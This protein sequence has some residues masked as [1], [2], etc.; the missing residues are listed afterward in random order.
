MKITLTAELTGQEIVPLDCEII[1]TKEQQTVIILKE[2]T[3]VKLLI[4]DLKN[5]NSPSVT[6]SNVILYFKYDNKK[7]LTSKFASVIKN[8]EKNNTKNF[9]IAFRNENGEMLPEYLSYELE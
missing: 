6:Y 7:Y 2:P 4:N 1:E 9:Y 5:E 3:L 8:I